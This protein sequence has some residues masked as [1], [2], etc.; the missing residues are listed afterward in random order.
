MNCCK[1]NQ[2]DHLNSASELVIPE[3]N[4]INPQPKT[5]PSNNKFMKSNLGR[6]I[7]S[8]TLN[9]CPFTQKRT[10]V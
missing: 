4:Y 1:I 3:S 5:P 9:V 7:K 8:R 10:N 2:L 6:D